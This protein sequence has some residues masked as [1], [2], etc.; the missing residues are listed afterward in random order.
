MDERNIYDLPE[1][2]RVALSPLILEYRHHL[3]GRGGMTRDQVLAE[4]K[5]GSQRVYLDSRMQAIKE[6]R[7]VL[8]GKN[9]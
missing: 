6:T 7:D 9:R 8:Q 2:E 3:A 4:A 1:R 5:S